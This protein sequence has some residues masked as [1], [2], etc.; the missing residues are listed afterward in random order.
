MSKISTVLWD[1][2][3]VLLT[4]GW[5]HNERK[6]V[7]DAL[8]FEDRVEFDAR[9]EQANDAWEKG[10]ID[11][12]EYLRRTIFFK[13]RPFTAHQ[14]KQAIEAESVLLEDSAMPVLEE[15]SAR[16]GLQMGQLNNES[17][18][19]ND[20]RVRRFGL[21]KY[22]SVFF[23]SGYVGL[24]KPDIAIYRFALEVLQVPA[25]EVVFIDDREKNI[26]AAASVGIRGILYTGSEALRD[27][28]ASL[29]LL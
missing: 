20:V 4:N 16:G 22:W 2:G 15:L 8:G 17:R 27:K 9:H 12:D 28:L 5:D 1:T 11:F 23:C 3:G 21:R 10:I 25:E 19:L 7:F 13:P 26:A 29:G 6:A 14:L 18:E 24:R